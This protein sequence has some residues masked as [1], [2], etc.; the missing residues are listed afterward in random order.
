MCTEPSE[1]ASMGRQRKR[2]LWS[3][4]LPYCGVRIVARTLASNRVVA[5]R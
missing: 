3:A 1:G 4:R 5:P 2:R